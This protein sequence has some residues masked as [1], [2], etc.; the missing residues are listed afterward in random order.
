MTEQMRQQVNNC[1]CDIADGKE[2]A[3]ELLSSLVSARMFAVAYS[4][5]GNRATA[6]DVTQNAFV[7][8]VENASRFKRGTNGYAWICKITQNT[9]INELRKQR[10]S[11][12]DVN[13]DD[14]WNVVSSD[15]TEQLSQS[16]LL[17]QQAMGV[18]DADEKQFVWLKYFAD[19][20][21]R[22]IAKSTGVSK[23][24]VQRKIDSA[25]NKMRRFLQSDD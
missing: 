13:L 2:D 10:R 4:V 5:V 25:E 24:T 8:I 16:R 17:L 15:D 1:I 20:T 11:L 21:V 14:M 9:A 22:D 18:L 6:E 19:F 12:N 23:S 7:K 3:L